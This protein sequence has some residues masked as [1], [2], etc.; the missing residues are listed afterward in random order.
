MIFR[1]GTPVI[2]SCMFHF[3]WIPGWLSVDVVMFWNMIWSFW[4]FWDRVLVNL[5]SVRIGGYFERTA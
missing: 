2:L 4:D 1:L 3:S 5:A